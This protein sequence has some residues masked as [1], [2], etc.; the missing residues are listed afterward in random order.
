MLE[1]FEGMTLPSKASPIFG[2]LI[3][4]SVFWSEYC[5]YGF[6]RVIVQVIVMLSLAPTLIVENVC[7]AIMLPLVDASNKP[8]SVRAP[9]PTPALKV[10]DIAK[11]LL[12]E[13]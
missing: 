5:L 12:P 4:F 7:R 10:A 2:F 3:R 8:L 9:V 6:D 1:D 11:D 13:V